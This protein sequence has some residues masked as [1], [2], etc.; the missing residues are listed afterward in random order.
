MAA[1]DRCVSPCPTKLRRD[2]A[3]PA[4]LLQFLPEE[5]SFRIISAS[6]DFPQHFLSFCI[7]FCFQICSIIVFSVT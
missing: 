7:V 1:W 5:G 2:A 3:S 6:S 4:A